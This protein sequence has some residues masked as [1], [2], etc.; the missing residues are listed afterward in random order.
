[1]IY[2]FARILKDTKNLVKKMSINSKYNYFKIFLPYLIKSIDQSK[3]LIYL[4][5]VCDKISNL[6]IFYYS[7][8]IC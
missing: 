3:Y 8:A 7:H 6:N 2:Y 4:I 5:Q 1:M